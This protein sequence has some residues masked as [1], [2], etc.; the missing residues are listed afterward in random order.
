MYFIV[1]GNDGN[2]FQINGLIGVLIVVR[3]FNQSFKVVYRLVVNVIDGGLF[4]WFLSCSVVVIVFFVNNYVL[5]FF[6][7][8]YLF[9]VQEGMVVGIIFGIVSVLDCDSGLNGRIR[10]SLIGNYKDVFLV[11][12]ISGNLKVV[13]W[14]DREEVEIYILNILVSDQ[15]DLFLFVYIE[16]YVNILDKNDNVL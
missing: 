7:F 8:F 3:L 9:N 12:L 10:Y 13:K 2:V 6:C 4:K 15:G 16:V 14:F 1:S 5:Q 11:E